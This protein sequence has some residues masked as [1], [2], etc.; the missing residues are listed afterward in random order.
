V[1]QVPVPDYATVVRRY[2]SRDRPRPHQMQPAQA[3]G[4]HEMLQAA[5]RA[6]NAAL[7]KANGRYQIVPLDQA[8]VGA[9][10][11]VSGPTDIEEKLGSHVQVVQLKYVAASEIRRI[12]EPLSPRGSIIRSDE[13]RQTI[14]LSGSEEEIAG[15]LSHLRNCDCALNYRL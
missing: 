8:A 6:N 3:S 9:A 5:L 12:L 2:S 14:T 7:V 11:K 13:A 15:M 10:I 1:G 4:P